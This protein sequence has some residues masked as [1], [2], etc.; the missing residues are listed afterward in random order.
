MG[1][2]TLT[3]TVASTIT[4]SNVSAVA[5]VDALNLPSF[6]AGDR[7]SL[8]LNGTPL[9]V[10]F[11]GDTSATITDLRGAIDGVGPVLTSL[12]GGSL[13]VTAKVPGTPFTFS[14]LGVTNTQNGT[15]IQVNVPAVAQIVD[16]VA[17]NVIK[18]WTFQVTVNGSA[19]Q[20]LSNANGLDDSSTVA[21]Q[22]ASAITSTG[23][24]ATASGTQLRLMANVPGVAF[25][26]S[27]TA[28]DL[29]AP[30]ISTTV[31]ATEIR[32]SGD[33]T[34]TKLSIDEPGN[35]FFVLSGSVANTQGNIDSLILSGS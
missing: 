28:T 35:I 19:Y 10:P 25:G 9:S 1:N 22:L 26:Y 5:Q 34:S 12:S 29:T 32:K 33:T 30:A 14:T 31:N 17:Y 20:Y 7:L 21:S 24:T 23:V 4:V 2:L 27:A 8:S 6:Y 18:K 13:I 15:I 16:V 11:N 3:N